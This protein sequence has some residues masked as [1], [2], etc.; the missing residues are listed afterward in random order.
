MGMSELLA[1][2][3]TGLGSFFDAMNAPLSQFILALG[4]VGG[5]FLI[6][7]GLIKAIGMLGNITGDVGGEL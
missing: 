4:F 6:V 5:I 1:E 7:F 2:S 3:G